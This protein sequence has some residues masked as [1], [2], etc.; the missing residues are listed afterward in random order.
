MTYHC[1]DCDRLFYSGRKAR[2]Q[3]YTC[4]DCFDD[5]YDRCEHINLQMHWCRNV[6]ECMLCC[7]R[8][9]I[10]TEIT[11]HEIEHHNYCADCKRQFSNLNCIRQ[12]KTYDINPR[13][14]WNHW[15]K[16]YECYLCHKL[17]SSLHGLKLHLESPL[18]HCLNSTCLREFTTLA[19][20][21]NHLESETC[22][23]MRFQQVQRNIATIVD[24]NR[25]ISN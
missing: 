4:S 21:I 19:A 1:P 16:A 10:K 13:L 24:S 25:M 9:V 15:A 20:P 18:Y 23:I 5:K 22:K 8:S 3:H 6:P 12:D 17:H 11:K 2:D 14:A 7:F